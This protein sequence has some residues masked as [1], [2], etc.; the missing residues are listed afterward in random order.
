M[1]KYR[2]ASAEEI[3]NVVSLFVNPNKTNREMAYQMISKEQF[4]FESVYDMI[5]IVRYILRTL[6]HS[7]ESQKHASIHFWDVSGIVHVNKIYGYDY[8]KKRKQGSFLIMTLSE[9]GE[10]YIR[11]NSDGRNWYNTY[12][13]DYLK[14]VIDFCIETWYSLIRNKSGDMDD[15][16]TYKDVIKYAKSIPNLKTLDSL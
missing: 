5:G 2:K 8:S 6:K 11:I 15:T 12:L 10:K 7:N 9:R 16:P 1:E 14:D 3:K 13:K 4:D